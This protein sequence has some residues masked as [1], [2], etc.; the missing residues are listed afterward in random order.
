MQNLKVLV[1]GRNK[2]SISFVNKEILKF[3]NLAISRNPDVIISL[4]GDGTFF[5]NERKYP[6]VPKVLVRDESICKLCSIYNL[7]NIKRVLD[8]L[9]KRKFSLIQVQK[10]EGICKNRKLVAVNDI[11]IR[12]KDQYEAIRFNIKV[13]NKK[14][15]SVFIGDGIVACTVFGST[16]YFN[17]ITKSS[18][19]KGIG[20]AF[21]NVPAR[22]F[23]VL[24]EVDIIEFELLRGL[25]QVSADN[26]KKMF[27]LKPKEKVKIKKSSEKAFIVKLW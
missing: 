9:N 17:A 27:V 1:L 6:G 18:L 26:N 11:I 15:N 12:N 21:N 24:K 13:N 2:N 23:E 16:G 25:A 10:I 4:G 8:F 3:K 20:L 22:N 14:F 19:S 5:Y 7:S